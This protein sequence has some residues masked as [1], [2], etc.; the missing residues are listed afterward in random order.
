MDYGI[1]ALLRNFPALPIGVAVAL[2]SGYFAYA[3]SYAGLR[4]GHSKQDALLISC[5]YALFA[6]AA[7]EGMSGV[8]GY[9]RVVGTLLA[10]LIVGVIWRKWL[11]R[12]WNSIMQWLGVHRDDGVYG[13]W[14]EIVNADGVVGQISV[15]TKDGRIL[16]LDDRR[17][18]E[19]APW[20]GL[21]L[22]SDESITMVVER[23]QLPDGTIQVRTDINQEGW[24]TRL[25]YIPAS[26]ITRVNIRLQ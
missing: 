26:S 9:L 20:G 12:R 17:K 1:I 4:R 14:D 15:H 25:T 8:S 2:A 18:Y 21:Y 3:I 16:Y 22:A 23:E 13:A 24:G 7:F 5:M 11:R 10:A 19:N 6:F